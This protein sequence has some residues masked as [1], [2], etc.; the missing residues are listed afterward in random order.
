MSTDPGAVLAGSSLRVT[1]APST[2]AAEVREPP[3]ETGQAVLVE[4]KL[5]A[6]PARDQ[7]VARDHLLERLDAGADHR[8]TL[9]A[10]PAGFGK[11]SL[12]SAWYRADAPRR[13]MAWLS[14]DKDDNDPVVL[15]S[16]VLEAL[17]RVCP[18]I[19]GAALPMPSGPRV[20]QLLL[21]RLVNTLAEQAAVCLILDDFH[22]LDDGPARESI[23]WLV[24]HA[25][26]TFQLVLSTRREPDLALATLRAHGDLVELRAGD[27]RFTPEEADRFLNGSQQL[28]L[29]SFDVGLLVERTAG[30][31]AGLYLAALSL[32]RTDARHDLVARF[33]ASNRHVTDFLESEVLAA[34]DPVDREL[35]LRCSILERLSG[36]LCDAVLELSGSAEALPRLSRSNLFLAPLDDRGDWYRFHPLFAQLLRVEL[37]RVE[38]GLAVGLHQRAYA[39]HRDRG[40][41]SEAID[42]AIEAGMHVDAADL[43]AET[44]WSRINAGRY[45]T[46]LAW[47]ERFP[48]DV[49]DRDVRLLLARAWTQSLSGQQAEAAATIARAEPL[50]G[51]DTGALPDGFSSAEASL[52]T[53]KGAFAWGNV[54]EAQTNA[55]RA[56]ELEGP[57]SPWHAAACWAVAM[58]HL[59][60]DELVEADALFAE[61]IAIAPA[62]GHW[63]IACAALAYRSL[64]AGQEGR[65]EAQAQLA[66]DSGTVAREHGLENFSAGPSMALGMSLN[67]RGRPAEALPVLKH[68]VEL[69]RFQGQ[70]ILLLRTLRCLAEALTMLG[71]NE[72][73]APVLAEARSVLAAC[74]DPAML[75]DASTSSS[76]QGRERGVSLNGQLTHRELTVLMF[77]A[78]DRSEA[79]IGHELFVSHSTV[80]SHVRSIYR[81]LGATSRA[82]AVELGRAAGFLQASSVPGQRP[83]E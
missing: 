44:W 10:C 25:P 43:V 49:L 23:A 20:V 45:D 40:A 65:L 64:I 16:Y 42:H 6:P 82:Q 78:G 11:T 53:L 30:W 58:A 33:G 63:L 71:R 17:H 39:W 57:G 50:V 67:A 66:E 32:R 46:V 74:V 15:W 4:T 80:H 79:D 26:P 76:R 27:L 19:G 47:I 5:Q 55:L 56:L 73:A 61:A 59:A 81:K 9:V 18:D 36:T 77:L 52:A 72:E 24:D 2:R 51:V 22:L 60:R 69:A 54:R 3:F 14:L 12:L 62:H 1:E 68:G 35:M 38:P 21:P 34:H 83:A 13:A 31:P 7:L 8:L 48:A 70:P 75:A 37:E 28:G 29:T 41:T